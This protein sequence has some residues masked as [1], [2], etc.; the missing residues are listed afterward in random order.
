MKN[1]TP[2]YETF[3]TTISNTCPML[4]LFIVIMTVLKLYRV[5]INNDKFV[6]YK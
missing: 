2:F 3:Y 4:T 6:F 1:L 5:F